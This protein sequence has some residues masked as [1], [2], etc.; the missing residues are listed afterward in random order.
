MNEVLENISNLFFSFKD[1]LPERI[2]KLPQS[3]SDRIYFRIYSGNETLIATYNLNIQ[4]NETFLYHTNHFREKNLS[5]PEIFAVNEDK[6]I[7]LQQDFG[8]A[9]LLD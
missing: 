1:R 6:T 5:V 7:Y 3:G 4:E 2:E 8:S 9:S